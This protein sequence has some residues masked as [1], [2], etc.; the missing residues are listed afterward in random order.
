MSFPGVRPQILWIYKK[1]RARR[2]E[3]STRNR[4]R[5]LV[6]LRLTR[7]HQGS[8]S[9]RGMDD[10]PPQTPFAR[11]APQHAH[12]PSPI[13]SGLA[14]CRS[15]PPAE[16]LP[17]APRPR[18]PPPGQPWARV[19]TSSSTYVDQ[20]PSMTSDRD[21]TTGV[22]R[23]T[24]PSGPDSRGCQVRRG[25]RPLKAGPNHGSVYATSAPG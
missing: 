14:T 22:S 18:L 20:N 19:R 12:D 4:A 7:D 23:K 3:K 21:G 1:A 16:A 15:L 2:P 25:G 9:V 6:C 17:G 5:S 11:Q 8:D 24:F 10:R 13:Q